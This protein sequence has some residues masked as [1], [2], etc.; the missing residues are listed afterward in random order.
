MELIY[1]YDLDNP[2]TWI[3]YDEPP[4]DPS[5]DET[6]LKIG[7]T[8]PYG[9]PML[10]KRWGAT[11][12]SKGELVYQIYESEPTLAGHQYK[13]PDS[14]EMVR[15][16][17][18]KEAPRSVIVLPY[19]ESV[20]LGELRIIIEK[21]VSPEDLAKQGYFDPETLQAA[22]EER[23]SPALIGEAGRELRAMVR[24]GEPVDRAVAKVESQLDRA[25]PSA[26]GI[27]DIDEDTKAYFDPAWRTRGDYQFFFR[28][29]RKNGLYHPPDAEALEGIALIWKYNQ[30]VTPAE[31]EANI[32]AAFERGDIER[33]GR[34]DA[35]WTPDNIMQYRDTDG[36]HTLWTDKD[37]TANAR[38]DTVI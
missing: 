30:D 5:F 34:V 11:Y 4:C 27:I 16:A 19:W 10:V 8:N 20:K 15:V 32:Q 36:L 6:L 3:V 7:G 13:D 23:I 2:E 12:R 24:A 29:E 28:L 35:L 37:G 26:S 18:E 9:E 22:A 21:W 38:I 25:R 17:T 33:D 14:G 1:E 31:H